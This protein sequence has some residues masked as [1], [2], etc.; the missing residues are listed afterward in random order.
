MLTTATTG[1]SSQLHVKGSLNST[2]GSYYR[3]EFF[4]NTSQDAGGY[5]EGRP[6]S[7]S[8][9]WRPTPQATQASTSSASAAV[10]VGR[11]ISA[12]ATRSDSSYSTFTDTSEFSRNVAA[13][14]NPGQHH[15]DT[16]SDTSDGDTTSL[17]H[18]ARQQGRRRPW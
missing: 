17:S 8:P 6:G 10:P 12:T 4:A 2:A 16:A 1:S 13:V 5:G 14:S 15:G 3:I 9:T 11:Y 7:V 18:P